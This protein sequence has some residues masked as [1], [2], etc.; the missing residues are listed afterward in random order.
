MYAIGGNRRQ[1]Y[2]QVLIQ[3]NYGFDLYYIRNLC[4]NGRYGK[5]TSR[6]SSMQP[7]V[8]NGA[9]MDAIAAVVL[10]GTSMAGG[11]GAIAGTVIWCIYYWIYQ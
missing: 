1:H 2:S 8:G 3:R 5:F 6:N 7:A 4:W 11:R 9:E 10:G